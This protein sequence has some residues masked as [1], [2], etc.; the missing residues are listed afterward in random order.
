MQDTHKSERYNKELDNISKA[1]N[2]LKRELLDNL[3]RIQSG[4]WCTCS[5]K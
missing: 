2:V 5:S 4:I 3:S 1:T